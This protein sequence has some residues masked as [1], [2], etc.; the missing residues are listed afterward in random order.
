MGEIRLD[1]NMDE[2]DLISTAAGILSRSA[3]PGEPRSSL[4]PGRPGRDHRFP[5]AST[6]G[7]FL[8]DAAHPGTLYRLADTAASHG[9]PDDDPAQSGALPGAA[10]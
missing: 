5:Y 3:R 7:G 8:D 4:R 6:H 1:R 2:L 9:L 10:A